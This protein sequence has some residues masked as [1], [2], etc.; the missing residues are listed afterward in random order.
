MDTMQEGMRK[1]RRW[2]EDE[3]ED[4][5]PKFEAIAGH[6]MSVLPPEPVENQSCILSRA[7]KEGRLL[8]GES[9]VSRK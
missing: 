1:K 2:E 6:A 7:L 9:C 8:K 3:D 5:E 4:L